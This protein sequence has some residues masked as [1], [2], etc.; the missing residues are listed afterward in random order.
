VIVGLFAVVILV[1]AAAGYLRFRSGGAIGPAGTTPAAGTTPVAGTT[2]AAGERIPVHVTG[3][4]RTPKGMA[5]V[6]E[7]PADLVRF[8]MMPVE[9]PQGEPPRVEA[10]PPMPA[11][12]EAAPP[13]PAQ[14]EAPPITPT[15]VE[16][17]PFTPTPA[18]TPQGEPP[19]AE[20]PPTTLIIERQGRPEGVAVGRGEMTAM[21]VGT[22]TPLRGDRPALRLDAGTG[23]LLVSFDSVAER[24]RAAAELTAET[25]IERGGT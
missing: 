8:V 15:T 24:D 25:G 6:R 23:T 9:P 20:E 16:A 7:A 21:Q 18:E 13:R 11:Q 1:G 10:A 3:E 22:V 2:L 4:L 12:V 17:P 19:H 14:V 5:H